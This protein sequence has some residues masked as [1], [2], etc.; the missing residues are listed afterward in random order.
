MIP[1]PYSERIRWA[2]AV[3]IQTV[4]TIDG[5]KYEYDSSARTKSEAKMLANYAKSRYRSARIIK[6]KLKN[7]PSPT[8]VYCV[9]VWGQKWK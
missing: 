7:Q 2:R 6:R 9:Y 8:T 1:M 5:K 4:K 3:G